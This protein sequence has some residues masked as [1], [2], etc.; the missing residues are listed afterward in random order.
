MP[1]SD[2]YFYDGAF[3]TVISSGDT[4]F[5]EN[6]Y[7]KIFENNDNLNLNL[8]FDYSFE[9]IPTETNIQSII[10]ENSLFMYKLEERRTQNED[11]S[12]KYEIGLGKIKNVGG[13]LILDRLE[14]KYYAFAGFEQVVPSSLFFLDFNF[15]EGY[16]LLSSIGTD[17]VKDYFIENNSVLASIDK[18]SPSPVVLEEFTLL[19]RMDG[20]IQSIDSSEL[21]QI[22]T[23]GN[24]INAIESSTGNYTFLCQTLNLSNSN[25]RLSSAAL[26][27]R[28]VYNNSNRPTPQRGMIIYNDQTN[29]LEVYDGSDWKVIKWADEDS[30]GA[31]GPVG[32]AGATGAT[33][34][35]GIAGDIGATGATGPEGP[36]GATGAVI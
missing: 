16:L 22:L 4:I 35:E 13:N 12:Y 24:I 18:N 5:L 6:S 21:R 7:K 26:Q 33:G 1:E 30:S 25:S 15:P 34:P 9:D 23:D 32:P 17:S 14:T 19:G 29:R 31:T 28:P 27:A 11:P 2:I 8:T 20:N 3:S 36:T 10:P